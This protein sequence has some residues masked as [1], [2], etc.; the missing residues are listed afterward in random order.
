VQPM[1]RLNSKIILILCAS[2]VC[3]T[4]AFAAVPVVRLDGDRLT[5]DVK[6]QP[7]STVLGML[8]YEGIRIRID[9]RINPQIT[10]TFNNRHIGAAMAGIL[11]SVDYALIWR[12]DKAAAPDEEPR[13]WEIRIFYKGQEGRIRPLKKNKNLTVVRDADSGHHVK[14]ILL[15]QLTP[16]MTETALAA[17]LDRLGA[18]IIDAF[19]PLGI[20]QLRL[21]HGSNVPEIAE[22]LANFP[23]I[24]SAEPDYAHALK[25]GTPEKRDPS[26]ASPP[27][28]RLPS[29]DATPIA[30]LDSGLLAEFAGNPYV[31]ATYDAVSPG[32][33]EPTGDPVFP[34]AYDNVIGVG[35]KT[36]VG[37]SF[38]GTGCG[39]PQHLI[40]TMVEKDLMRRHAGHHGLSDAVLDLFQLCG[41]P[42]VFEALFP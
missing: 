41:R 29:T 15:L 2:V 19:P 28:S 14:D 11:R 6:D 32:D 10:A 13:L 20:V 39:E 5:L 37:V 25:G 24:R 35:A 16:A 7:L 18:T 27:P 4:A 36:V 26:Q 42:P 22:S 1:K 23:G 12:K 9:P 30:I 38:I 34:A 17:L 40:R 8:S 3:C 21:P 31:K 33:N